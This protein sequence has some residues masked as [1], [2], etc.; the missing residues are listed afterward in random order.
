MIWIRIHNNNFRTH[1]DM[2]DARFPDYVSVNETISTWVSCFFV[3]WWLGH[4]LKWNISKKF[5]LAQL[6]LRTLRIVLE[7]GDRAG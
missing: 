4:L 1:F 5:A 6:L 3:I 7:Q 2:F